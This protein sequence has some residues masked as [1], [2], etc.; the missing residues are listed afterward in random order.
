MHCQKERNRRIVEL[1]QLN[2]AAP[3]IN[4]IPVKQITYKEIADIINKEFGGAKPVSKQAIQQVLK[5]N[6][7]SLN[8]LKHIKK[9]TFNKVVES[10]KTGAIWKNGGRYEYLQDVVKKNKKKRLDKIKSIIS[11]WNAGHTSAETARK[12]NTSVQY[13]LN[14]IT[15]CR[16]K[17]PEWE[18][19][20]VWSTK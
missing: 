4:G 13:I 12:F 18:I 6:G 15:S 1:A 14:L 19:R 20:K 3:K 10:R 7:F 5:R 11:F 9:R 2:N 17:Y 8:R 16:Q